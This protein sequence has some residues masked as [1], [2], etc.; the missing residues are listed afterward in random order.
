MIAVETDLTP[1]KSTERISKHITAFIDNFSLYNRKLN[2][3]PW[4]YKFTTNAIKR[5]NK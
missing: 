5:E 3:T 4:G 1:V 2:A